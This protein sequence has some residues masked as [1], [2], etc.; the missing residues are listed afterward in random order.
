MSE[1]NGKIR[2][3]LKALKAFTLVELMV[4]IAIVA[5]L[6]AMLIPNLVAYVEKA[7]NI[8]DAENARAMCNALQAYEALHSWDDPLVVKNPYNNDK[9]GYIYVD[10][11]EIRTSSMQVAKILE[12][13]GFIVNA[14]KGTVRKGGSNGIEERVYPFHQPDK[15]KGYAKIRCRSR[16]KAYGTE[17]QEFSWDTY[18]VDFFLDSNGN[19]AFGYSAKRGK[20]TASA[21]ENRRATA[22]FNLLCQNGSIA[23]YNEIGNRN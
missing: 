10:P 5:V 20:A 7:N 11:K 2:K 6:A 22:A 16:G 21:E 13:Q 18:Q 9:R 4:V 1:Q 8:A 23:S 17:D 19:I 14:D 12:E 3:T 15:R